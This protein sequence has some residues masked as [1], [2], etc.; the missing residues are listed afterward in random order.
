MDLDTMNKLAIIALALCVAAASAGPVP[1]ENPNEE[2]PSRPT[3]SPTDDVETENLKGSQK[4]FAGFCH[5]VRDDFRDYLREAVNNHAAKL[6]S[7]V[8]EAASRIS[9]AIGQ[10]NQAAVDKGASMVGEN[11]REL[12]NAFGE[13][14]KAT[15]DTGRDKVMEVIETIK[16]NFNFDTV[17]DHLTEACRDFVNFKQKEEQKFRAAKS[18]V[19]SK[20]KEE[21]SKDAA[22]V[23]RLRFQELK[24]LS[25]KR[26]SKMGMFCNFVV[27]LM[28]MV[29]NQ[30]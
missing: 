30:I 25:T 13:V 10:A 28:P 21:G 26:L 27:Q 3:L 9:Q 7:T 6:F 1:E 23:E 11:A 4:E 20:L 22:S 18:E 8:V 2:E 17:R 16:E 19:S 15:A 5:T 24:C 12:S 29:F 14:V